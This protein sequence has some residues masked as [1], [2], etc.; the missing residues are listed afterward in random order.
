MIWAVDQMASSARPSII[1][2]VVARAATATV[3]A[4]GDAVVLMG[5]SVRPR[6]ATSWPKAVDAQAARATTAVLTF[7]MNSNPW[8][9][10]T[11]IASAAACQC[12]K[13]SIV[14]EK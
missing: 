1:G 12:W 7:N 9:M 5:S 13:S 10:G 3:D 6:M 2:A 11:G 8:L 4:V 14:L